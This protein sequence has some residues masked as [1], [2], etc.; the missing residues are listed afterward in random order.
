MVG[1][2]DPDMVVVITTQVTMDIWRH[3]EPLR[4]MVFPA[5]WDGGA[6][7]YPHV[8]GTR[9]RRRCQEAAGRH[10]LHLALEMAQRICA[11]VDALAVLLAGLMLKFISSIFPAFALEIGHKRA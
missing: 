7:Y 10:D 9:C 1:D 5:N 8:T 4:D 6:H 3:S 11:S 2:L